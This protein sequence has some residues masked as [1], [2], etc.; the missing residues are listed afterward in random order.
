[1]IAPM[2]MR[3]TSASAGAIGFI[4]TTT[5]GSAPTERNQ[6][7]SNSRVVVSRVESTRFCRCSSTMRMRFRPA[8]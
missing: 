3:R 2:S 6:P 7:S 5:I 8:R 4:S 1:M